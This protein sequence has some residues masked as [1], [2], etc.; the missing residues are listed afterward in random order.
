MWGMLDSEEEQESKQIQGA[1][2]GQGT[3]K[4]IFL[5]F[6]RLSPNVPSEFAG[7]AVKCNAVFVACVQDKDACERACFRACVC[8]RGSNLWHKTRKR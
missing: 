4:S 6:L 7:V 5:S 3:N 1:E 8:V 2:H